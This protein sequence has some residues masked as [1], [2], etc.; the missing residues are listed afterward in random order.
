M[1]PFPP[2]VSGL[3]A[4]LRVAEFEE[5]KGEM[6]EENPGGLKK[7]GARRRR[8]KSLINIESSRFSERDE[9][10]R[11]ESVSVCVC[12]C[13]CVFASPSSSVVGHKQSFLCFQLFTVTNGIA[14]IS[15]FARIS[16]YVADKV[17]IP[18]T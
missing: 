1:P 8:C 12:V 11:C 9:C 3:F 13:V 15:L 2:C 5:K 10:C 6:K 16:S 14:R 18:P 7:E 4:Q 17:Q